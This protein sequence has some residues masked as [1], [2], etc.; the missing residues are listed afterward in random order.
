MINKELLLFIETN[1]SLTVKGSKI[2]DML[3]SIT[4]NQ[5]YLHFGRGKSILFEYA[6]KP[7]QTS[8]LVLSLLIAKSNCVR[9][10]TPIG[11]I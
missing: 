7:I 1:F 4:F 8:G 10:T 9:P 11:I 5:L 6:F 2:S 3:V